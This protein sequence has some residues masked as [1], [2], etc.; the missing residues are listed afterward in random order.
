MALI[1]RSLDE[2]PADFGPSVLTVGNFDG[3]HVGHRRILRE[4]RELAAREGWK[5]SVLTFDPHPARVVAPARAPRLMTTPAERCRL[6]EEEGIEQVLVLPFTAEV[7][8]W[9][10]E[11][12]VARILVER[13]GARAVL[14]G[15]NFRFGHNHAG[16]T[17]VLD[18]LGRRLGFL[19][20]VIAAVSQRGQTVSSSAIRAAVEAGAVSRARRMLGRPFRLEGAVVRGHGVGAKQT[21]PTLNLAAT[22]E[23]LPKTGVYVTRTTGLDGDRLWPSVTNFGYRPTFGGSELS[24]ESFLLSGLEGETPACIRVEFLYRLRDERKFDSPELLKAQILRDATRARAWF[25]REAR[26]HN[27]Q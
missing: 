8:R 11:E 1:Y 5:P 2:T 21:V 20:R 15:D 24:V 14:V 9:S 16:D 10:P 25:R 17:R 18:D 4:V 26:W 12:F 23:V 3:V 27:R 7:A 19:T 6:M 22:A 13:L